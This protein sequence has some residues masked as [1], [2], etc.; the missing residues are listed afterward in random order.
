[1]TPQYQNKKNIVKTISS[2]NNDV[3]TPKDINKEGF[4]HSPI[5]SHSFPM[6][7]RV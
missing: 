3:I 7:F 6:S 1:M 4:D 2:Q 5:P